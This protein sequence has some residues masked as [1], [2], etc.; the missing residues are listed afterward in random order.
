MSQNQSVSANAF[1]KG[2]RNYVL[3]MLTVVYIFNFVDRQI[4]V[5]LQESIKSDLGLSDTQLGLLSGFS[6]AIFYVTMGIPIAR[7]ADRSNRR[8]IV[9]VSLI[10]W[11]A[12]TTL[13]GLVQNYV[14]LLLARIGVGVGEAGGSPPAHAMIS[15]Y[16]P[17]EKRATALSIYSTGVYLGILVG[18]LMGGYLNQEY[19]WRTAFF[20]LGVPGVIYAVLFY[21][22]VK[23]PK[24]GASEGDTGTTAVPE[25]TLGQ[26]IKLLLSKKSFIFLAAATGLHTFCTYGIGNWMPP[27][28]YRIHGMSSLEIGT[29]LGLIVGLGGGIGTFSGGIIADKLGKT[30]KS[31]YLKISAYAILAALPFAVGVFF[32]K[33]SMAVLICLSFANIFYSMFLGPS[34]AITHSLVPVSMRAFSSA[35]LFFVLN[36]IGLGMGPLVIGVV[37]DLLSPQLGV[38]SLR[39][40]LAGT[41]VVSITAAT[42]FL[43][44]GKKVKADLGD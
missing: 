26:V 2:Y 42:L 16:F 33:S 13:S 22:T 6:F 32:L 19:G 38:E 3:I 18:Y 25:H 17:P 4:L 39:W 12:M 1:S 37:S 7:F 20:A 36:L 10:I 24:R 21:F 14:Q 8:N 11:S 30:D 29:S 41:I 35:I 9:T 5:I 23:E 34:I 43:T 44:A 27:F 15:D 31:W 28:L 40:A